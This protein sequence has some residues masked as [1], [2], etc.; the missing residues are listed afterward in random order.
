MATT[1]T[2]DTNLAQAAVILA[3]YAIIF[4]V[5]FALVGC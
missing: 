3:V 5:F 1:D 2:I 4:G